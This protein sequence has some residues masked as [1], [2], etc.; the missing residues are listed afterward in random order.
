MIEVEIRK[1]LSELNVNEL[2]Q[3]NLPV[4]TPLHMQKSEEC[5]SDEKNV[6]VTC[7]KKPL[8]TK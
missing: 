5:I 4:I 1:T 7:F 3:F 8:K 6:L 2:S